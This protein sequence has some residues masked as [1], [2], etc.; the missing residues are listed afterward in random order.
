MLMPKW[1]LHYHMFWV[2]SLGVNELFFLMGW[3]WFCWI[4]VL[5]FSWSCVVIRESLLDDI[6]SIGYMKTN[7][8]QS[9]WKV[10][11]VN[12][13]LIVLI[14]FFA[15]LMFF[16]CGDGMEG[17]RDYKRT[18][19]VV[20]N[21]L[22]VLLN[23]RAPWVGLFLQTIK[24][25]AQFLHSFTL[26]C[27]RIWIWASVWENFLHFTRSLLQ[28]LF[29][30]CIRYLC[31]ISI[32]YDCRPSLGVQFCGEVLSTRFCNTHWRFDTLSSDSSDSS[33]HLQ[34]EV[35][36]FCVSASTLVHFE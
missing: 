16:S 18:M 24:M 26:S 10:S 14:F 28:F 32:L 23:L 11:C 22:L 19:F 1:F 31:S 2:G 34:W 13:L 3:S 17:L 33:W 5:F 7:G 36:I 30:I 35:K 4:I 21:L 20:V 29:V 12:I 9:S 25:L 8:S 6:F 15:E 27:H